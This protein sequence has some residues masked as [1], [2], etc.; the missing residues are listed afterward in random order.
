MMEDTS[1]FYKNDNGV[2]LYGPNF[3]LNKDYE[4]LRDKYNEYTY[5]VD[6]WHW[7]DTSEQ[8]YTFFGIEPPQ[9]PNTPVDK[10]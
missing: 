2:L 5:P 1:G 4:L 3:V 9:D 7:F 6:G 10:E 8:A